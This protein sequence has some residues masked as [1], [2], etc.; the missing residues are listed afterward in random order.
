MDPMEREL[1]AGFRQGSHLS[2]RIGDS[3]A[4]T[5][6][7]DF[8]HLSLGMIELPFCSFAVGAEGD[9]LRRPLHPPYVA[10]FTA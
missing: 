9:P 1:L 7:R 2:V 5:V 6:A 10:T 4:A 3:A 8:D